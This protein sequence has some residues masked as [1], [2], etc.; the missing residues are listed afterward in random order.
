M[1]DH[2]AM[3]GSYDGVWGAHVPP[4]VVAAWASSILDQPKI[5]E[6][7]EEAGITGAMATQMTKAEWKKLTGV[8]GLQASRLAGAAK[9]KLEQQEQ[10][11]KAVKDEL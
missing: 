10:A 5:G 1:E 4:K 8:T 2:A 7:V 6:M 9:K 3:C 11:T